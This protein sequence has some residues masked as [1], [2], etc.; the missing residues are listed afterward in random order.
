MNKLKFLAMSFVCFMFSG[1]TNN[2]IDYY[3]DKPNK[4]DL[5]NFF[6]G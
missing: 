2:S 5:R 4:M 3:G 1:C 6:D